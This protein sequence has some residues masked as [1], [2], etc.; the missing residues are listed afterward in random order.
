[1]R[2]SRWIVQLLWLLL[3]ALAL[4]ACATQPRTKVEVS[5][6]TQMPVRAQARDYAALYTPIP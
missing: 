6:G 2:A 1:M 4:G 3:A 5:V